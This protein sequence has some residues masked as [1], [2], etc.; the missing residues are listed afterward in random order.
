MPGEFKKPKFNF[1]YKLD[2]EKTNFDQFFSDPNRA[3]PPKKENEIDLASWNIANLGVQ[4][5]RDK[6]FRLI[7]HV[8]SKFDMIAVQEVNVNLKHF[9]KVV[10]FL[11]TDYD[12]TLTDTAGN[13]ERL[14]VVYKTGVFRRRQLFGEL[15]YNPNGK[16]NK[17][18]EYVVPPKKQSFKFQGKKVELKFY[19]FN[20]NPFLSTWEVIGRN[21]T[22]LLANA[23]I[24]YGKKGTESAKFKNR[25]A[26]VYFLA[27]WARNQQTSKKKA[28]LYESN[29]ILI[30]DMNIPKMSSDD[31][32]YRALKR[33][34]MQPSKYS[35]QAGTTIQEFTN[36]DQ[37][38]FTNDKLKVTK[39]NNHQAVVVDFDNFI[40][41]NLWKQV[42]DGDRTLTD[43]KAWVKFAIS[44]HRPIFVR[45]KV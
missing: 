15:D 9:E 33:R 34:G 21:K 23:H 44:D 11:G 19:N 38:V 41:R 8:L 18:G 7:A 4:K 6:D 25:L 22:F 3:I 20:R 31:P 29:I 17:K 12:M 36:Y 14:A 35:T 28:N 37:I 5:R 2:E 24:Y 45:L 42:E 32:V 10:D 26:E 30:G 40:L 16:I 39:I 1:D 13:E 27:D 43:F